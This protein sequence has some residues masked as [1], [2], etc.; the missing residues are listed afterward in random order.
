MRIRMC[1][2][3][4]DSVHLQ[5]RTTAQYDVAEEAPQRRAVLYQN[6][7]YRITA[8]CIG[9]GGVLCDRQAGHCIRLCKRIRRRQAPCRRRYCRHRCHLGNIRD[10]VSCMSTETSMTVWTG[11]RSGLCLHWN[12]PVRALD[13]E[14]VLKSGERSSSDASSCEALLKLGIWASTPAGIARQPGSETV[15]YI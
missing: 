1:A 13:P 10:V 3:L 9:Q 6:V 8:C 7:L 14:D 2:C 15:Q 5:G 11:S 12:S 4:Y